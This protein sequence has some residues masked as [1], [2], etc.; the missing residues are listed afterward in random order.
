MQRRRR[1]TERFLFKFFLNLDVLHVL[2]EVRLGVVVI[3]E[4]HQVFELL[5]VGER[6]H[7]AGQHGGV[8]MLHSLGK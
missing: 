6:L 2:E 3:R 8:L 5:P 1:E 4:L 7:Q